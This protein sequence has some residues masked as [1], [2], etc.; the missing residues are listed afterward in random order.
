MER[1]PIKTDVTAP[2]LLWTVSP[3]YACAQS[4][5]NIEDRAGT[6]RRNVLYNPDKDLYEL[7]RILS[8]TG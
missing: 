2:P 8:A 5:H 1:H 7:V 4:Q 6:I 3:F